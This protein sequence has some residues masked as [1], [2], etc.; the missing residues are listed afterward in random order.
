MI[1][2]AITKTVSSATCVLVT[3]EIAKIG[4]CNRALVSFQSVEWVLTVMIATM[5][6]TEAYHQQIGCLEVSLFG[7]KSSPC[8]FLY[9]MLQILP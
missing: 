4:N 2:M 5:F 9:I 6:F 1:A 7:T 3:K 8:S